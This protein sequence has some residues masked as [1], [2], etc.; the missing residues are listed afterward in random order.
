MLRPGQAIQNFKRHAD[1]AKYSWQANQL[2]MK[3][4]Q[5]YSTF[6]G[7]SKTTHV[8]RRLTAIG[9]FGDERS[10]FVCW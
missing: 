10:L 6:Y 2:F 1:S 5:N 8:R 3:P 4:N 9:A 7:L